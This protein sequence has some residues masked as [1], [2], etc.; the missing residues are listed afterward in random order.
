MLLSAIALAILWTGQFN[1]I[2]DF[3][4]VGLTALSGLTV[5]SIFPLRARAGWPHRFRMPAYPLPPLIFL[6]LTGFIVVLALQSG[7][8]K[9][10]LRVGETVLRVNAVA[11]GSILAMVL[12]FPMYWVYSLLVTTPDPVRPMAESSEPGEERT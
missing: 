3:T 6:A 12:G 9:D 7:S 8:E 1:A 4:A 5:A 10:F 11:V 2:L